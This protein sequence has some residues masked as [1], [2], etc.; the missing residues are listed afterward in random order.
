MDTFVCFRIHDCCTRW[1]K[2]SL[3][4]VLLKTRYWLSVTDV[5]WSACHLSTSL[6]LVAMLLRYA[7]VCGC[8]GVVVEYRTCNWEVAGLTHTWSTA[9]NHEQVANLMCAQ[10]NLASY[11]Q[12][13]GKWVVATAT[14]WRPSVADWVKVKVK[15]WTSGGY[16]GGQGGHGPF[17]EAHVPILPL[18]KSVES[19][20]G[21]TQF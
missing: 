11:P 2:S 4:T 18:Q 17:L 14:G 8:S 3:K 7:N 6:P 9:N 15:V 10:V 19:K 1:W 20:D 12:R 5:T 16:T 21:K 13:D